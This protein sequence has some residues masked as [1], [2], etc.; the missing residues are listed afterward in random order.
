MREHPFPYRNDLRKIL[1]P[2][3]ENLRETYWFEVPSGYDNNIAW[4]IRHIAKTE[5][6]WVHQVGLKKA[7]VLDSSYSSP[8]EILIAYQMIREKTDAVAISLTDD[9]WDHIVEVP[10]FSDGWV[11]PSLPT[12]RWLFHHVYMHEAYHIGQVSIIARGI[13]IKPPH[14]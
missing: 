13:G 1:I 3:L 12:F 2:Y 4:I 9:E 10:S 8:R 14:F 6:F 5:D 11:P 7:S